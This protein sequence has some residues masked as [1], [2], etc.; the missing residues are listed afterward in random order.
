MFFYLV[1]VVVVGILCRNVGS[2]RIGRDFTG[3]HFVSVERWIPTIVEFEVAKI[4]TSLEHV[5][6]VQK[7][8]FFVP[9]TN[10]K[11]MALFYI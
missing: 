3:Q 8:M 6:I 11:F 7:W 9:S 2:N 1:E 10:L 4:H 5:A